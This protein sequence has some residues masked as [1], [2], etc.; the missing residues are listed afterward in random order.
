MIE[1]IIVEFGMPY[2]EDLAVRA[3]SFGVDD[4]GR[5]LGNGASTEQMDRALCLVAGLRGDE[6]QQ[7]FI[8]ARL[9]DRLSQ[10][11]QAG[12]LVPGNM[13][14]VIPCANP[15]SMAIGWR[16]W[17]G[18]KTDINRMF[19]GYDQGETT[20]RIAAALF[21][22]VKGFRF[23]VHFASF[24]LQG[25]FLPHVRIMH[26]QGATGNH[27]TDFG[28]PYV[29]HH[30]PGSFDTTTLHY[31]WRLWDTEAYTLYTKETELVNEE[32]AEEIVQAVLRFADAR[33]IMR[34]PSG[35]SSP[36]VE[37]S[38]RALVGVAAP[39]GGVFC[40]EARIG[41]GVSKGD[42]LADIVDPLRG[43]VVAELLS[44]CDGVVLY[45]ARTPLVNEGTLAFQL[46]PSDVE[47]M[48]DTEQRGNFLD[49]EA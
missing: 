28:L 40:P 20:Q 42:M 35:Q 37:I 22:Q 27:G 34:W 5:T 11:E 8:C 21:E 30:V 38:E 15:A 4:S 36:T 31:N 29:L 12:V 47:T 44:P 10:M 13:I 43:S 41:Q 46:V 32:S 17:P 26:G 9:V 16:F 3:F 18:D 25:D 49:P 2:R 19:P 24:H 14:T 23:G 7:S 33:G 39:K 6:I 1:R 48:A 45:T